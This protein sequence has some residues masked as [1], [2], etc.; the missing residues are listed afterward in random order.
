MSL[1]FQLAS[2]VGHEEIISFFK[3][4]SGLK[5]AISDSEVLLIH[6]AASNGDVAKVKE[7][8]ESGHYSPPCIG[9]NG[10]TPVHTAAL[11]GHVEVVKYL[12]LHGN[13][14]VDATDKDGDTALYCAALKGYVEVVKFLVN[15]AGADVTVRNRRGRIPL[16]SGLSEQLHRHCQGFACTRCI[17]QKCTRQ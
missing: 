8:V 3:N 2:L 13:F 12:V 17:V 9:L 14:N 15:E 7:L 5:D 4:T 16:H 6:M 10:E 1:H 11:G